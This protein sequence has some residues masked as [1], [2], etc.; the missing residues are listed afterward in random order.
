VQAFLRAV[1]APGRDVV[2]VSPFTAYL[3]PHDSLRFLNYAIPDGDVEPGT[4][5]VAR[6]R[7]AFR[8]RERLPRLE[9]VEDA[10]PRLVGSLAIAGMREELRTP[11]LACA[12]EQLVHATVDV[13]G[14]VI[15]PVGNA[16]VRDCANLQRVAF[17]GASVPD[18]EEIRDPRPSGGGAIL[19][20]AA[21]EPVS[22]A[23]WTRVVD[24]FTEIVGVATAEQWRGRGLA[25]AV[26]AAAA[27]AAFAAGADVCVLSPGDELAQR[28]YTRAG[29]GRAA[30]ML[31][32]SDP[33]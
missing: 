24:G 25:G 11:L 13:R 15:A 21:G 14:L 29:F 5:S 10:A 32:W 16:D 17:G 9:W 33:D 22:A 6:L 30:T 4:D 23:S 7:A 27:A 18:G 28:V 3:D 1:A 26:T 20:R 12:P 31:H 2:P 8:E 19:A